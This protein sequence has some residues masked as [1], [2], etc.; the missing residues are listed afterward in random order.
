VPSASS[1]LNFVDSAANLIGVELEYVN[2]SLS[3]QSMV[4]NYASASSS[5]YWGC[6]NNTDTLFTALLRLVNDTALE[7]LYPVADTQN[8]LS[9]VSYADYFELGY[10]W[11]L[12][13]LGVSNSTLKYW[14]PQYSIAADDTFYISYSTSF[15]SNNS[16]I[17][18]NANG[19]ICATAATG[20]ATT[21][22]SH[23]CIA[24]RGA[25]ICQQ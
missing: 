11:T 5:F 25:W 22:A 9:F 2:G 18:D 12:S 15:F 4:N 6:S 13:N 8:I 21:T 14:Y 23:Y 3:C 19:E 16:D 1:N 7:Q 17:S 10:Q 20:P 24:N